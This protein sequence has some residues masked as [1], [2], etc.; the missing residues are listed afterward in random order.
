[1]LNVFLFCMIVN[2]VEYFVLI[3]YLG[4]PT[5]GAVGKLLGALIILGYMYVSRLKLHNV[6]L[7][8]NPRAIKSGIRNALIFNLAIIPAYIVEF[9]YYK[10][11]L[12]KM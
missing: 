2:V 6:G 10:L 1:M 4:V 5:K 9:I 12:K 11:F 7:S 3:N 8:T